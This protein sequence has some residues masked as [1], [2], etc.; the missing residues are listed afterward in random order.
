MQYIA[1]EH[2]DPLEEEDRRLN[3]EFVENLAE[4]CVFFLEKTHEDVEEDVD[5]GHVKRVEVVDQ[6][7]VHHVGEALKAEEFV[8]C[9]HQH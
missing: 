9:V 7:F 8:A 1:K 4:F 2:D 5:A 6:R 3:L